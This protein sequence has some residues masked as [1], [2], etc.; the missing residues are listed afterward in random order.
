MDLTLVAVKALGG[1]G[2]FLYGM[3]LMSEGLQKVAGDRLRSFLEKVSSNRVIGALVG[4]LVTALVQSSSLTTVTVVGFV[5]AGLINLSQAVGVILGANVGTTVTAQIIAFKITHL[6]LIAIFIGMVLKVFGKRRKWQY[7]GEVILGFGILF[8]GMSLM[9]DGFKPLRSHPE[10]IAFFTR[11]DASTIGGIMLCV[12][13]GAILTMLVQSS[14]A[15]VGITMAL[16]SQGLL[17]L[18]G[19][20]ALILGENIGTT[21][22]AE[23]ASIGGN[24]TARRAARAHTMFNVI[25]VGMVVLIFNP[26]LEMVTWFTSNVMGIGPADLAKGAERPNIARYIANSH[27]LFNVLNAT[28]FLFILP[29]LVKAAI[30]L[31]PGKD[32]EDML[33]DIGRT[34]YIDYKFV[35]QPSVALALARDEIARMGEL[36][37]LMHKDV[38]DVF[39]NRSISKLSH[40]HQAEDGLDQLQRQVHD[41]LVQISQGSISGPESR[42]IASLM[43]MANNLERVGDSVENIAQRLEQVIDKNL[44][45]TEES[46]DDYRAIRDQVSKFL[47]LVV[48]SIHERDQDIMDMAQSMEDDIDNMRMHSRDDHMTRLRAGKCNVDSGLVFVDILSNLEKIGD[49]CYNVSQAVA[50]LR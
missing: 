3:K 34:H 40:W 31:T 27:T 19:C 5:N 23:L 36:A 41:Y 48:R 44:T 1:L 21:I 2:L 17:N 13:T 47:E 38:T 20:V 43:R 26:F 10:F 8:F 42:E 29:V 7:I 39:F 46:M 6:A 14:S 50:G 16:A 15:T 22:T 28:F 32:K 25:G 37:Q 30:W 11:F 45:F 24:L 4:T 33:E 9:K 49:Y 18:P 12:A 35:D